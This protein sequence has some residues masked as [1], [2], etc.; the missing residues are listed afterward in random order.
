MKSKLS[1]MVVAVSKPICLGIL[2]LDIHQVADVLKR[3]KAEGDIGM[4]TRSVEFIL[5]VA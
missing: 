1:V 2:D 3:I 4:I 5:E